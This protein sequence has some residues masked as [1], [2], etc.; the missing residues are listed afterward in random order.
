[1]RPLFRLL[2]LISLLVAAGCGLNT[3]TIEADRSTVKAQ[4]SQPY[5]GSYLAI[6]FDPSADLDADAARL[7]RQLGFLDLTHAIPPRTCP[8]LHATIGYFQN[9]EPKQAQEIAL[10][11]RGKDAVITLD[12]YG[13]YNKQCSYFT[14]KGLEEARKFL[15]SKGV[16]FHCDDPHATFGVCP[17]NPRDA[18]GVPKKAQQY[19]GPY[20]IKGQFHFM[21]GSKIFW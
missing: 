9:L 4:D 17:T 14:V 18:H 6:T 10:A 21:Q 11:F 16:R 15:S 13:V 5:Q 1:M 3:P 2:V 20:L 19:V 7:R 8:S 12:G